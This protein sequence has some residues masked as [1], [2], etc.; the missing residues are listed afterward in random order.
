M[1]FIANVSGV[2][3]GIGIGAVT[4]NLL[5]RSPFLQMLE[6]DF[7]NTFIT[8]FKEP[9][10]FTFKDGTAQTIDV[11]FDDPTTTFNFQNPAEFNTVRPQIMLQESLLPDVIYHGTQIKVRGK[12]YFVEDYESNG[13]GVLTMYMRKH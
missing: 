6:T 4:G 5:T 3:L 10:H 8:D 1:A 13:V 11:L 7:P 12:V 2:T 9:A